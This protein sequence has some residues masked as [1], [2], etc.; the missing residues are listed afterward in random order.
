M[1][2]HSAHKRQPKTTHKCH[3]WDNAKHNATPKFQSHRSQWHFT[4]QEKKNQ[5]KFID[6]V[7][8]PFSRTSLRESDTSLPGKMPTFLPLSWL[9]KS[10]TACQLC[11]PEKK[12]H[13][14]GGCTIVA[15]QGVSPLRKWLFFVFGRRAKGA[16][17][18][19]C[20]CSCFQKCLESAWWQFARFFFII[21]G[22]V[23]KV[24]LGHWLE[25]TDRGCTANEVWWASK[26]WDLMCHGSWRWL[27]FPTSMIWETV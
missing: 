17:T 1:A 15:L 2:S 14:F 9:L 26:D 6:G 4:Q 16:K 24:K 23:S 20:Y 25:E 18:V 22:N 5:K 19:I 13:T 7:C 12:V 21:S 11:E 10:V 3:P 8:Q 27:S